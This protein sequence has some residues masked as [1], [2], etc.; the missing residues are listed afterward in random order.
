M[1][2]DAVPESVPADVCLPAAAGQRG[3]GPEA[4]ALL[5]TDVKGLPARIAHGVVVPWTEAELVRVLSSGA[6]LAAFRNDAAEVRVRQHVHPRRR[7]F[8][9]VRG[10][11]HVFPPVRRESS[12]PV[13]EDQV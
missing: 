7:C 13:E 8:P 11:N 9:P 10:R 1:L 5:V 4:T 3:G 2:E 12:E 6:G